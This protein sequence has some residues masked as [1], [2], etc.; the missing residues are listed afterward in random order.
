MRIHIK[1]LELVLVLLLVVGLAAC[2]KAGP[3]LRYGTDPSFKALVDLPPAPYPPVRFLVV[4]DLHIYDVSLGT[5]GD[6]FEHYLANDRKLLRESTEILATVVGEAA[7]V[8]ADFVLIPGDLTKDGE[9][10]AHHL[11]V[12]YLNQL[13]AGGKA[14]YVVPG[15]HDVANPEAVRFL[16]DRTEPVPNVTTDQ[17]AQIYTEFGYGEALYRD[18]ASLSY[19]AEPVP[20]LWL[21][22]LDACRYQENVAGEGHVVDGRFGAA[23]LEWMEGMLAEA[24]RQENAVIAM[25]HHGVVEHYATQE[26]EFGEYLVDD[27]P[28]ISR[29]LAMY[30]ARLVF[31]GHYHAQDVVQ[32]HWKKPAKFVFDVET[33][34]LV[35]YPNPYRLV[36][37]S[38]DQKASIESFAVNAIAS[39][40][41]EFPAYSRSYTG[42]GIASIATEV[43]KEYG[44]KE[45]E[46]SGL[47]DQIAEAFL[48][49]YA[50]DET[51]AEGQ[52]PVDL[53]GLSVRGWLVVQF[54]KGLVN[55]LWDD[56]E[57]ADNNLTI[58]LMTGSWE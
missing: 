57:P 45:A 46:A 4:S 15:N 16:G 58:D 40:P 6:A 39:H 9:E 48:A 12:G 51:L 56:L 10:A 3:S 32:A 35:S 18:P 37:I 5:E 31:T 36:S 33:G 54:R 19:V 34:S 38:A 1:R 26:K 8:A 41:D 47:A 2:Q 13:E 24:V 44:V 53:T 7:G 42:Q 52:K 23:T 49:H 55:G 17:F 25:M 50:G 27:Y 22:A 20:G 43:I 11:A 21:L 28:T 30:N 14:V 29:L